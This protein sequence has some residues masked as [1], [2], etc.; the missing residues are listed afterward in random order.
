MP[1]GR[2]RASSFSKDLKKMSPNKAW[3]ISADN[4]ADYNTAFLLNGEKVMSFLDCRVHC[5]YIC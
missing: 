3:V 4:H 2:S 1:G 5:A